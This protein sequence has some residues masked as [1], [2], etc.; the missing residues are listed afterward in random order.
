MKKVLIII[1]MQNDFITGSIPIH[2]AIDIIPIINKLHT[3][4]QWDKVIITLDT[5][6]EIQEPWPLHCIRDTEGHMLHKDILILHTDIIIEKNK[7]SALE[8]IENNE[9]LISQDIKD[10]HFYLCGVSKD[11]C[12]KETYQDLVNNGYNAY[13]ID[14]AIM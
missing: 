8:S 12:V 13:I 3:E 7:N 14:N 4:E 9:A 2:G 1:D 5:H 6:N 10:C 11:Y